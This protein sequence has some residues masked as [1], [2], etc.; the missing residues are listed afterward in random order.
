MDMP[1]FLSVLYL[2]TLP[3]RL[4]TA[5]YLG[6]MLKNFIATPRALKR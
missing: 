6:F 1:L 5:H 2:T 4:D 3:F